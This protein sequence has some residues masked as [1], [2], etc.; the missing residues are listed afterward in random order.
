[1]PRTSQLGIIAAFPYAVNIL[2]WAT[3]PS[4]IFAPLG[5]LVFLASSYLVYAYFDYYR[6]IVAPISA[7]WDSRQDMATATQ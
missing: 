1:V 3:L 2:L 5:I 6:P 4:T 7:R